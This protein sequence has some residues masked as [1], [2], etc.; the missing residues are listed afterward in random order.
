MA[1]SAFLYKSVSIFAVNSGYP[2]T[3]KPAN[4]AIP[5]I[6]LSPDMHA[7]RILNLSVILFILVSLPGPLV[8]ITLAGNLPCFFLLLIPYIIW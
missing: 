1:Q 2:I 7:P 6:V 3:S 8:R 5:F 4:L